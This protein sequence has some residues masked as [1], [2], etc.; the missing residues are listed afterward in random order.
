[1]IVFASRRRLLMQFDPTT[2]AISS[3]IKQYSQHATQFSRRTENAFPPT[4]KRHRGPAPSTSKHLKLATRKP[5]K[6]SEPSPSTPR[7]SSLN[8]KQD[9]LKPSKKQP[10]IE[11]KT[12]LAGPYHTEVYIEKEYNKSP[13]HLKHHHKE[14]PRSSV[15]NFYSTVTDKLPTYRSIDGVIIDGNQQILIY[16]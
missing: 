9:S 1:M 13:I 6:F 14:T 15:N 2:R 3:A 10:V 16:R 11:P 7:Q 4:A 12:I 5:S 8:A